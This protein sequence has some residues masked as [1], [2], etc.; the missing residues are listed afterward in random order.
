MTCPTRPHTSPATRST[1]R[2]TLV[3]R[4]A[5][6]AAHRQG[7]AGAAGADRGVRVGNIYADEALWRVR[8]HPETPRDAW[9]AARARDL[10]GA[11]TDV[12]TE[13]LAAGGTSIDPLY[14]SVNGDSGWSTA[15][16]RC[17][18]GK[19]SH[20][21]G[22]APRSCGEQFT[23][24]SSHRCPLLPTATRNSRLTRPTGLVP[25]PRSAWHTGGGLGRRR[26][27]PTSAQ[28]RGPESDHDSAGTTP[29]WRDWIWRR[30]STDIWTMPAIADW[31]L[32]WLACGAR[33]ADLE[34]WVNNLELERSL[35]LTA[36]NR[37]I[38]EPAWARAPLPARN[39]L[40]G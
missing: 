13:A 36:L 18:E 7:E 1:P 33:V 23:N 8:L 20:V 25:Q 9:S 24:R 28:S 27:N 3:P 38:L 4:L 19:E 11:A 31:L 30:R 12:M 6:C 5:R 22:A 21:T 32:K 26:G 39:P 15:A 40:E 16:W 34:A 14:V 37:D 29:R 10:L 35:D 2:T 17:T